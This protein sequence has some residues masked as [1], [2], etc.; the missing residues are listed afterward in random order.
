MTDRGLMVTMILVNKITGLS[1]CYRS[2]FR[3]YSLLPLRKSLI[4]AVTLLT[5]ALLAPVHTPR[6]EDYFPLCMAAPFSLLH[7]SSSSFAPQSLHSTTSYSC[8]HWHSG[9]NLHDLHGHSSGGIIVIFIKLLLLKM[10][11]FPN[12]TQT[13]FRKHAVACT[14]YDNTGFCYD[15]IIYA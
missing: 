9:S 8:A 10:L 13:D 11:I 5:I 7:S 2:N 6:P 15:L 1:E 3:F 14:V 12:Y 4:V